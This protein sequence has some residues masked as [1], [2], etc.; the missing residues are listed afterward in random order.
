VRLDI[1]AR[2][3]PGDFGHDRAHR[4]RQMPSLGMQPPEFLL[5]AQRQIDMAHEPNTAVFHNLWRTGHLQPC[6]DPCDVLT[7]LTPR[8]S[9]LPER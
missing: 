9:I 4:S 7:L 5:A 2:T 1:G 3:G 8:H 6:L